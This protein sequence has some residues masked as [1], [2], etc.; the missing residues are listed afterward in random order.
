MAC[1]A[2]NMRLGQV[3]Q[4][5][6]LSCFQSQLF[7]SDWRKHTIVTANKFTGENISAVLTNLEQPMDLKVFHP[8]TQPIENNRCDALPENEKCEFVCVPK[9]W[10]RAA[11]TEKF[12]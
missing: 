7:W 12:L 4:I 1:F 9:P 2:G 3:P 10:K 6:I 5:D 11:E 8:V